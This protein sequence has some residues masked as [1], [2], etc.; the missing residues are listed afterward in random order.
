MRTTTPIK[1]VLTLLVGYALGAV[2]P[3]LADGANPFVVLPALQWLPRADVKDQWVAKLQGEDQMLVAGSEE[4]TTTY[5][6]KMHDGPACTAR[7]AKNTPMT[8]LSLAPNGETYAATIG[9]V[10]KVGWH[11]PDAALVK[12]GNVEQN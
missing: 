2:A 5:S 9:P 4:N 3:A 6:I 10:I 11:G 12:P 1:T 8:L 7:I